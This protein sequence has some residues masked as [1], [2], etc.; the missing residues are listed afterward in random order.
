MSKQDICILI[1]VRSNK[2]KSGP[3]RID[4]ANGK[5]AAHYKFMQIFF[6]GKMKSDFDVGKALFCVADGI[7]DDRK[8]ER[9]EVEKL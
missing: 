4:V 8:M 7:V 1:V 2:G 3:S 5:H 6:L 9:G